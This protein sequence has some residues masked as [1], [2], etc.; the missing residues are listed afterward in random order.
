MFGVVAVCRVLIGH[1]TQ[2]NQIIL[3]MLKIVLAC[4]P[5]VN[6]TITGAPQL[7]SVDVNP[8]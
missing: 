7:L 3:K 1:G 6:G 8:P 5:L 4:L 2:E